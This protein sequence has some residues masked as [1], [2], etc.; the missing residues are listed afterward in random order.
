MTGKDELAFAMAKLKLSKSDFRYD[1]TPSEKTPKKQKKKP[2]PKSKTDFVV[3][4][5]DACAQAVVPDASKVNE[6]LDSA[7]DVVRE[8]LRD[9]DAS[10]AMV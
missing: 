3:W 5:N 8:C 6:I 1:G 2:K 7:A 10:A 9:A 4:G